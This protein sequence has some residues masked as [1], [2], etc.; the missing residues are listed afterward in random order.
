MGLV[1]WNENVPGLLDHTVLRPEATKAD[2]L[3][4]CE[5]AKEQGFVVIFVPPCYVDEAVAAVAGTAVQVG[6]PIGFPLGG[7][8]THAKV[9]E[10]IEA[11]AHGARVLDMVINISRLKSGDHDFVRQ[12]MAAV[13]RATPGVNHKVILETCLLTRE[14]KVTACRLAVE[15]GMD[16]VKTSTGFNQA[17]ATV[18]DVRLMKEAVAGRAK[19][20]ASGGIRDWKSTR[21][22]LEAGADRI[23]TSASLKVL[24][25]WRAEQAANR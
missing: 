24:A 20:K 6:I 18:E 4:L 22:L 9:T 13:V 21:A 25:E 17:G 5:E 12:D 15:A 2:V 14:E 11:V 8:S 16:Y 7:H 19:V 3:R 10:A 23:G 1:S